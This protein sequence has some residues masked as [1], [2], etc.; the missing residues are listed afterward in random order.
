VEVCSGEDDVP[1]PNAWSGKQK[2]LA[3]DDAEDEGV[4]SAEPITPNPIS[5]GM[6]GQSNPSVVVRVATP[7]L[8][9]GKCGRKRPPSAPK[10]NRSLD[11]VMTQIEIP[12]YCGPRSPLD[13]VAIEIV[14]GRIFE[15]S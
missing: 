1:E 15:V 13:L 7:D 6:H 8:P 14:F 9:T 11:Q 2:K 4:S 10:R 12:L 3:S 5:Y